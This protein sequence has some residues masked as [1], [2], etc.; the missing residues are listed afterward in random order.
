MVKLKRGEK[1]VPPI[2]EHQRT[3][4]RASKAAWKA[5]WE[6]SEGPVGPKGVKYLESVYGKDFKEYD[7]A[8]TDD[9]YDEKPK[10]KSY[11][12]KRK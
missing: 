9:T 8:V 11:P 3:R 10:K 2:F 12:K 1:F 5:R 7:V 6:R 4:S